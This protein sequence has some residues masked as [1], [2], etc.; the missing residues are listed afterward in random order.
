MK[1][2]MVILSLFSAL[3]AKVY[4]AKVEPYELRDISSNVSGLVVFTDENSIGKKLSETPYIQIDSE[5]DQKDLKLVKDKLM[6]IKSIVE[7][8]EAILVNLEESLAKKRENYK[9]I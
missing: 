5:I 7:I 1:V 9:K 2:F 8:N 6:Y 3:S 4:Y